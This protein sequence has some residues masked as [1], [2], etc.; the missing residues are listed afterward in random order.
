MNKDTY[1]F[2]AAFSP[3]EAYEWD[4]I[5]RIHANDGEKS[6]ALIIGDSISRGCRHKTAALS[7]DKLY[8]DNLATSKAIDN[9][10]LYD[11][12]ALTIKQEASL[13]LVHFNNGLHGWHLSAEEYQSHYDA[14]IGKLIKAFPDVLFILALS[15]PIRNGRDP[16]LFSERNGEVIKRNAAV[17][18]IAEKYS[19]PVNDLYS[20]IGDSYTYYYTDGV[21]FTEEGY[22]VLSAAIDKKL[23]SLI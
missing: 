2:G 23:R 18:K 11:T 9:P 8:I 5:W 13:S 12:V 10:F 6:R 14:L 17:V 22:S 19:L 7:E 1:N 15:T 4:D 3:L 21:H 16:S 20:V